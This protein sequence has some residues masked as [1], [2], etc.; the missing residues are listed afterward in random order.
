MAKI[1]IGLIGY[2]SWTRNAYLPALKLDTRADIISAA[3]SS[4]DTR[5][6]IRNELGSD[7]N[8]YDGIERLL[9]GQEIDAVM[10]AVPD[11]I[12]EHTLSAALNSNV[13]VFYEPPVTDTRQR[14]LPMLSCLLASNQITFADL[15][16][17][18]I[19]AVTRASELVQT[20]TIGKIQTASIRLQ[21]G[22]G[23]VPNYNLCNFNHLCT[24]YVDVL[25]RILDA[26]PRRVLLL[27]GYGT[28]GRRQNHS[29]G[30]LD[31]DGVWGTL[32][33]NIASVGELEITVEINGDAGDLYIN[34]LNGEIRFRSRLNSNWTIEHLPALTPYADWPG[35]HESISTFLDAVEKGHS[36]INNALAMTELQLVG[37]AAEES[38]DSGTWAEVKDINTLV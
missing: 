19:P 37:L 16:L 25:N 30:H 14:L 9:N 1:R 2:G 33:A 12:H 6:L 35:M 22:W 3:A 27:D 28:P 15:E 18:F 34:I 32:Q 8:V 7:I 31:Y 5:Q 21:S 11:S 36:T 23:P 38:R 29:I 26:S 10:I 24:W 20:D 17:G 13:A 4:E